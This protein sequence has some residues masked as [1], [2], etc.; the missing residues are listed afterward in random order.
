[1]LYV[2]LLRGKRAAPLLADKSVVS[3]SSAHLVTPLRGN[4]AS[5]MS[6]RVPWATRVETGILKSEILIKR[7]SYHDETDICYIL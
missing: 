1:M 3:L 5:F 7:N 6:N 4:R 2:T